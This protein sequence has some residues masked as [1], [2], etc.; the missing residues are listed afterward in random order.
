MIVRTACQAM[1]TRF[2]F[3][4]IGDVSDARDQSRLR[5]VAQLLADE[6]VRLDAQLSLFRSDSLVAHVRRLPSGSV[7]RLDDEL[8]SLF[9]DALA[10]WRDSAGCFDFTLGHMKRG[11]D[12]RGAGPETMEFDPA[13][14]TLR[15]GGARPT[16][17]DFGAIAKGH[18]LDIVAGLLREH[19]V[20]NA[21][22]HGGTSSVLAM[23]A[24]P[25]RD[26]WTVQVRGMSTDLSIT[27]CDEALSVS[28][29][30]SAGESACNRTHIVDPRT[31]SSCAEGR[32]AVI[33]GPSAR[34][35]DAWSTA[36][37]VQGSRPALLPTRYTCL[38]ECPGTAWNTS[39]PHAVSELSRALH[40]AETPSM[41]LETV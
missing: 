12:P 17:L 5:A 28:A 29:Q 39:G 7:V 15:L 16:D 18:A 25:G 4:L 11:V 41:E 30:K 40:P 36:A 31:A 1:G 19:G 24:P 14:R 9:G 21:F 13:G 34:G 23:G 6:V 33:I 37:L 20:Q 3:A 2:E 8:T 10:V 38:I 32:C 27:L 26:G 35:A 22:V